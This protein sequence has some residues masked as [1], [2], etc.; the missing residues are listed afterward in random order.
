MSYAFQRSASRRALILF[1]CSFHG[2]QAKADGLSAQPASFPP[3]VIS[4]TRLPTLEDQLGSSVTVIT[5]D[6]IERKQQRTLPDVL[7]DVPGLNVVQA[8][9]PGGAAA[10][11]MRGANANHTKVFIDGIDV[12]DSR[13]KTLAWGGDVFRGRSKRIA[14]ARMS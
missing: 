9:G 13:R 12:S 1:A 14:I 10:V 11:F 8:G 5:S 6:D 3:L 7:Q 4:A 2:M